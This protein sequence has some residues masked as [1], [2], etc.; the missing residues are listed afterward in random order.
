MFT[1]S[2]PVRKEHCTSRGTPQRFL[3]TRQVF[4]ARTSELGDFVKSFQHGIHVSEACLAAMQAHMEAGAKYEAL[5]SE[6]NTE[7]EKALEALW[8]PCAS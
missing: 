3:T 6:A 7:F 2:P 4:L 1:Y 5:A 8:G